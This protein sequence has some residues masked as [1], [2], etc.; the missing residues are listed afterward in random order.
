MLTIIAA[1]LVWLSVGRRLSPSAHAQTSQASTL[2][3][4]VFQGNDFGYRIDTMRPGE[5]PTGTL[6]VQIN[7]LWYEARLDYKK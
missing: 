3:N 6:V 4:H 5:A 1:C 7:G 2:N